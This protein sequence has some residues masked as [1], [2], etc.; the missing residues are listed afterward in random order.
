LYLVSYSQAKIISIHLLK[1]PEPLQDVINN[2]NYFGKE[3]AGLK[4]FVRYKIGT[5]MDHKVL[6]TLLQKCDNKE[7]K[8]TVVKRTHDSIVKVYY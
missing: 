2:I 3:H 6:Y 5:D 7:A 4:G 8:V 1:Y